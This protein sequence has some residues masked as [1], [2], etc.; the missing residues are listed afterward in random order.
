MCS[1]TVP[2]YNRR[3]FPRLSNRRLAEILA[4]K[5]LPA[6]T[7]V[8]RTTL[9]SRS[10]S[11]TSSNPATPE[12]TVWPMLAGLAIVMLCASAIGTLFKYRSR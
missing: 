8:I 11:P 9:A 5:P 7:A 12:M 6:A 3:C 2:T 1:F 4:Y 10:P